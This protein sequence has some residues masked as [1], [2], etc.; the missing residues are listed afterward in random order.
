MIYQLDNEK[1]WFPDPAL[2]DNDGLLAVGGDLSVERLLLAYNNGIFPWFSN[3]TP[4]LWY[5]PH[6]RYVLFPEKIKVSKSMKQLIRSKGLHVTMNTSFEQVIIACATINRSG[7]P[8][9]WITDEMKDAYIELHVQG[10]AHSLEVWENKSLVGGLYGVKINGVFC[11]ES[12]FSK[13]SN[14]SK[15]ALITLCRRTN[16]RMIDCQMHNA[17]LESMGAEFIS[18]AEYIKILSD[19]IDNMAG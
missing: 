8:G 3:E 18:R 7:Q 4:I 16:L 6:E 17:H 12:M 19:S 9:T 10:Y 13:V 1:I 14:A 5:S 15:L 11:G 2:A